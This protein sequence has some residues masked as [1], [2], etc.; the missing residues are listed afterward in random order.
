MQLPDVSGHWTITF[1]RRRVKEDGSL[2]PGTGRNIGVL[3]VD[4]S[5]G[6]NVV[7]GNHANCTQSG[8]VFSLNFLMMLDKDGK[9][10]EACFTSVGSFDRNSGQLSHTAAVL[11]EAEY[12]MKQPPQ[13][14]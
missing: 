7:D 2:I 8:N 10:G 6:V 3:N 5:D 13:S 11:V 9:P 1:E 12:G 4:L 14:W